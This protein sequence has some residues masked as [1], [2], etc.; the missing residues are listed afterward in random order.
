MIDTRSSAFPD[1]GFQALYNDYDDDVKFGKT[2]AQTGTRFWRGSVGALTE[3]PMLVS[4][5]I[6]FGPNGITNI[7]LLTVG[8]GH[9]FIE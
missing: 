2:L 5:S 6:S 7:N 1:S 4:E 3:T 8:L 9:V